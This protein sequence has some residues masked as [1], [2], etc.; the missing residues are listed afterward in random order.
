MSASL[1]SSAATFSK[2]LMA[3]WGRPAVFSTSPR[4]NHGVQDSGITLAGLGEHLLGF[5]ELLHIQEGDSHVQ[6]G[7]I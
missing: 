6:T 4:L 1:G 2:S 7:D 5:L 3:I